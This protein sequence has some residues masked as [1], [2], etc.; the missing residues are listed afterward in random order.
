MEFKKGH[1]KMNKVNKKSV[2]D[3]LIYGNRA[4]LVCIL[5]TIATMLD[6]VLCVLQGF[7]DITYKH[8]LD[9]FILCTL[10]SLTLLVFRRFEKLSM[11]AILIIHFFICIIMMLLY[12]WSGTLYMELHPDAY[13]DAVRTVF[14]V[15]PFIIGGGLI[16]DGI[17][18]AKANRIL[19]AKN[20]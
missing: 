15:Y 8:L 9:R 3:Y 18:T 13:R 7:A 11:L 16:I 4:V 6:L 1:I 17:R 14:I 2:F 12:A 19:R 5:F 20:P 10:A